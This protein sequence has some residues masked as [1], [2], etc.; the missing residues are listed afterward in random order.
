M[1]KPG[2]S[3]ANTTMIA[4]PLASGPVSR[5]LP[6]ASALAALGAAAT[7]STSAGVIPYR[8]IS[9]FACRLKRTAEASRPA[10][11]ERYPREAFLDPWAMLKPGLAQR[12]MLRFLVHS[13]TH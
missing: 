5:R 1:T 2:S 9:F 11:R 4:R 10:G 8:R 13:S 3:S 6:C 12:S 7:D